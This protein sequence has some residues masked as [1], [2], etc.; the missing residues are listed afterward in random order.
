MKTSRREFLKNA[1]LVTTA[2]SGLSRYANAQGSAPAVAGRFGSLVEDPKRIF[3]L[4]AGFKYTIIGRAGDYMDDGL[5]LPGRSD[6]MGAFAGPDGKTILVRNHELES[7][8][9]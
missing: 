5:R 8:K 1:A 9:T 4:P 6:G 2:F 7:D 3:D